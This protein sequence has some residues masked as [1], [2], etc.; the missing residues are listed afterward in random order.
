MERLTTTTITDPEALREELQR[1]RQQ[2]YAVSDGE[3]DA[4]ARAVA[5]PV[6]DGR[7]TVVAAL[8][9]EAPATRMDDA[10]VAAYRDL[11][12][13]EAVTIQRQFR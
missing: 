7:N 1:I 12:L 4:G 11:L 13:R 2:E 5:V 10:G 9:I 6:Y 8:S 3:I